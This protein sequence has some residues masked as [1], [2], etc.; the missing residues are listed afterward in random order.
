MKTKINKHSEA[1]YLA[2][3]LLGHIDKTTHFHAKHTYI[4]QLNIPIT[5]S[6]SR[7][8]YITTQ[9]ANWRLSINTIYAFKLRP[10][11]KNTLTEILSY[12]KEYNEKENK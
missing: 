5:K 6:A 1:L 12:A 2:L 7:M 9:Q 3:L 11:T 4:I 10:I 8:V